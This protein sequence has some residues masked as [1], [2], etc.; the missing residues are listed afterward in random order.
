MSQ[1]PPSVQGSAPTVSQHKGD[2][3]AKKHIQHPELEPVTDVSQRN[4][5]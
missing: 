1:P 4:H 5:E 3:Q 2:Q